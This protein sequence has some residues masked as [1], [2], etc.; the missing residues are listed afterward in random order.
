MLGR[1]SSNRGAISSLKRWN[2]LMSPHGVFQVPKS[3]VS[4]SEAAASYCS[5][6]SP[7]RRRASSAQKTASDVGMEF[8]PQRRSHFLSMAIC[9]AV[10]AFSGLDAGVWS[11]A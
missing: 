2:R 8:T 11:H 10:L 1:A 9:S 5:T 7:P 4:L 6:S 3:A